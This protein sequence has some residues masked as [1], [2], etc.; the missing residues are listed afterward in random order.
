MLMQMTTNQELLNEI[1]SP[2]PD[3]NRIKTL[4]S[5][6]ADVN[7]V[8]HRGNSS[9]HYACGNGHEKLVSLLLQQ[10][11]KVTLENNHKKTPL[12]M[13]QINEHI[14]IVRLLMKY[15]SQPKDTKSPTKQNTSKS[16]TSSDNRKN[17]LHTHSKNNA[18]TTTSPQKQDV[19]KPPQS[20][21]ISEQL[22]IS[23]TSFVHY[24]SILESITNE[25][26]RNFLE[27]LIQRIPKH[28]FRYFD[29]VIE[30]RRYIDNNPHIHLYLAWGY[31]KST[32]F[33]K[34]LQDSLTTFF[35]ILE[36]TSNISNILVDARL[37]ELISL[38]PYIKPQR[39]LV[40]KIFTKI[41][42]EEGSTPSTP[43]T[44]K[45]NK[46]TTSQKR[47]QDDWSKI[48]KD[49][50][51]EKTKAMKELLELTGLEEVKRV[52]LRMYSKALSDQ[53]LP[54]KSRV[55]K[56]YNF[57]FMG[58]PGTGK[59]TVAKIFGTLLF[60]SGIRTSKNFISTSAP[61]LLNLETEEFESMIK[62]ANNGVLFI[63]EAYALKPQIT[64]EGKAIVDL[65]LQK[66]EELR[67]SLT[68][69][70]AGYKEDIENE[71][72]SYNVGMK[73]RFEDVYFEDFSKSQLTSIWNGLLQKFEW[74]EQDG[75]SRIAINRIAKG[76]NKK[77]FGNARDVRNMFEKATEEAQM[78]G[79]TKENLELQI[80]DII[81]PEPS[82]EN[83][84][85][86]KD[87]LDE[88]NTLTGLQAVK[89]EIQKL[90]QL[91]Q[92]NYNLE[93][94]GQP[95]I[96][97]AK[98]CQFIGNPGTGKTTVAK[99]YG[100]I[101]GAL[102]MLSKGD[103]EAKTASDF[104]GQYIGQSQERTKNILD[105][106]QGKVLLIDEAYNLNDNMYGKQVL[107][108]IV[109]KNTGHPTEDIAIVL[110]GYQVEMQEMFDNQNPGLKRR[111][112][113]RFHFEDYHE[114]ELLLILKR[115]VS[116]KN[117]Q[118]PNDVA[119]KVVQEIAKKRAMPHFGNAGLIDN[120]LGTIQK[121]IADKQH[122]II[123]MEDIFDAKDLEK[124]QQQNPFVSFETLGSS[125]HIIKELEPIHKSFHRYKRDGG[126]K[127][128]IGNFIFTGN[129]GTG[130]TTVAQYMGDFFFRLGALAHENVHVV[131]G[132]SLT[133]NVVG[134]T[135]DKVATAFQKASGGILFVDEA[136]DLG[137]GAYGE[138]ALTTMLALLT[139]A[140]YNNDQTIVILAGYEREISRMLNRN[141]GLIG[142]FSQKIVFED[143][144]PK[145]C[146]TLLRKKTADDKLHYDETIDQIC[147]EKLR[148]LQ[149]VDGWANARDVIT[150][151]N[152]ALQERDQR[153]YEKP[154]VKNQLLAEDVQKSLD[155]MIE[156]RKIFA[157]NI[158]K[159]GHEDQME[160]EV[161]AEKTQKNI[162]PQ[163]NVQHNVD[164][165]TKQ[166]KREEQN[167]DEIADKLEKHNNQWRDLDVDIL[168]L[169]GKL[170][171][172]SLEGLLK[173]NKITTEE[174]I[175][176]F[177]ENRHLEKNKRIIER[178]KKTLIETGYD[179][180]GLDDVLEVLLNKWRE[181]QISTKKLLQK[182]S[183]RQI[184]IIK[185]CAYCG[186]SWGTGF[187]Q[188]TY[189]GPEIIL[190][191][192]GKETVIKN[193]DI[194]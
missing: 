116:D 13:A 1:Q 158:E 27:D 191:Q 14:S 184:E 189:M 130:K 47:I 137:K 83:I 192:D 45:H 81:G 40:Q 171:E 104:V 159:E 142:R 96:D 157:K 107:D 19:P 103:V 79:V 9:L 161:F 163:F 12:D 22:Q 69:I 121:K 74:K 93:L 113:S 145:Q 87:A 5:K 73:S 98:N 63:D 168:G 43:K 136:Y 124:Q 176:S 48:Q 177:L 24:R 65:I 112:D 92:K 166:S 94:S 28:E 99:I 164:E 59:T 125:E 3:L 84:P 172:K 133:G 31:S 35:S 42:P 178:L 68:F 120:I 71:L 127:P 140:R 8:D 61:E 20:I 128:S 123:E 67:D 33:E 58:N 108:T 90:I 88:L 186:R 46:D 115:K 64:R 167:E 11:A 97:V 72:Y 23:E 6:G 38:V 60:E 44:D 15:G 152:L 77:G 17:D 175:A 29:D 85:E 160:Q 75:V 132:K 76:I 139:D 109:E 30:S 156:N 179:E 153:I 10:G 70:L 102:R 106:C 154:E 16:T 62:N 66:S 111:F 50:K 185:R 95:T 144:K 57:S 32:H 149:H 187:N 135:K 119:I 34:D 165:N 51:P 54:K 89:Q 182:L 36:S 181:L 18:T 188:C 26:E 37:L 53:K 80:V 190:V 105:M 55:P 155:T 49:L 7:W 138:E 162:K 194:F 91:T 129:A 101:L 41:Y 100:R 110:C 52:A 131:S 173:Q 141:Q 169:Q 150:L 56:R 183:Q 86:L 174:Q 170:K 82:I 4:L 147:E 117:L 146:F 25:H 126:R 148:I 78:R 122:N 118:I 21:H 2:N 143:W 151:F 134:E 180:D 39:N 193:A 114:E